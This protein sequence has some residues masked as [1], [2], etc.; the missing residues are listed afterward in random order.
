MNKLELFG[1]VGN[2]INVDL[3]R[4]FLSKNKGQEV[5][6][7]I[8]T[9]GGDLAQA[10]T[11]HNL[12][13]SHDALTVGN[14]VGLTASAGTVILAGCDKKKMS[15]NALFLIHNGWTS[16]TGNTFDL[17]K[18]ASDLMKNDAVMVKIYRESTGLQDERIRELMKASD[19]LTPSEALALGFVNEVYSSGIKIAAS[20]LITEARTAQINSNLILKLQ[21]KMKIFGKEKKDIPVM[22]VLAL[23]DG[24]QAL[25]NAETVTTGVEIAPLGAMSLEDGEYELADGRKIVVTGGVVTEVKEMQAAAAADPAAET[26]AIVAAVSA[27]VAEEVGKIQAQIDELRKKTGS[28]T[29]VKGT[30]T[31]QVKPEKVDVTARLNAVVDGIRSKIVESRKA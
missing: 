17:Q 6:F 29:P 1:E 5:Q 13:K 24:N 31:A 30:V 14:V 27:I 11:I 10:I 16:I 25:I 19:W 7:D 9:M 8:S 20:V 21:E 18:T 4:S 23:K 2:E 12:I 22:N 26:E 3:V 15:D 28:H